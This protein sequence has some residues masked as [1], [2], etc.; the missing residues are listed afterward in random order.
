M[1]HHYGLLDGADLLTPNRPPPRSLLSVGIVIDDLVLFD[2]CL[3]GAGVGR[4]DSAGPGAQKLDGAHAAYDAALLEANPKKSVRD[5]AQAS[6]WG[7][8]L[9]GDSGLLR[10]SPSR[11]W[12]VAFMTARVATLGLVTRS[13]LE[14]LVGSWAAIFL[15]RRRML[16]LIDL[17]FQALRATRCGDVVRLSPA[18]ADE[19]WSWVLAAPVCVANLRAQVCD[20][21]FTT[22]AS[23]DRIAC[24]T[25]ELPPGDSKFR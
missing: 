1:L 11:V 10:A 6:F 24:A 13:L 2:R 17:A 18:L 8:K 14:G 22:D 4:P 3:R 16:S 25:A 9:C 5:A 19:L 20:V 21:F 7:C 15:I 23:D 12:P